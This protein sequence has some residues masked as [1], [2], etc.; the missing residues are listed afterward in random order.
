MVTSTTALQS[1]WLSTDY[2]KECSLQQI[3]VRHPDAPTNPN[4][5]S[6]SKVLILWIKRIRRSETEW[7]DGRGKWLLPEIVTSQI[8]DSEVFLIKLQG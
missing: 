2:E 3:N 8:Q 1:A 6:L 7:D 5:T 4:V